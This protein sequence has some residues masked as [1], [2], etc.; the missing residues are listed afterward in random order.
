MG[1]SRQATITGYTWFIRNVMQISDAVLPDDSPFILGS[2]YKAL[3]FVYKGLLIVPNADPSGVYPSV[4]AQAVYN[5]AGDALVQIAPDVPNAPMIPGSGNPGLP[6][7][8]NMRR[9]LGINNFVP[10]VISSTSDEST[11]ESLLNPEFMSQLQFSDLQQTKTPWG[12]AYLAI[13]QK[14][15]PS[16]VGIN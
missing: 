1:S 12:R 9:T 8:A 7:F 6:F 11:S 14:Y 4:Y 5:F 15:G 2:Y 16:V 13:A 10:G 3:E